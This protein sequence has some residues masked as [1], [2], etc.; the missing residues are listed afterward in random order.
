MFV[1]DRHS[2]VVMGSL[3]QEGCEEKGSTKSAYRIDC[4]GD[5]TATNNTRLY[6]RKISLEPLI[7]IDK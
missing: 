2:F 7:T 6:V 4:D 3:I 5:V 1:A